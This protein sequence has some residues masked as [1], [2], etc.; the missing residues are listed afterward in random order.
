MDISIDADNDYEIAE[1]EIIHS[2]DSSSAQEKAEATVRMY[3]ALFGADF[4]R[5]KAELRAKNGGRLSISDMISFA[6]ETLSK[7]REAKN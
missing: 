2:S 7:V 3:H 1:F 6:N 4:G 5:I